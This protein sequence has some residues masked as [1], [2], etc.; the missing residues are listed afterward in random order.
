MVSIIENEKELENVV[1]G[2]KAKHVVG[3]VLGV[4][5]A[6]AIVVGGKFAYDVYQEYSA[7]MGDHGLLEG[8]RSWISNGLNAANITYKSPWDRAVSDTANWFI[9]YNDNNK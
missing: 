1:G 4:A 2:I 3:I 5:G 8:A 7:K 6:S 9:D